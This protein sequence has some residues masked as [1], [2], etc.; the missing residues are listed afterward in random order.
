MSKVHN[1]CIV[2]A[3][4]ISLF[5]IEAL[6]LLPNVNLTA[7]CDSNAQR[8]AAFAKK[9]GIPHIFTSLDDLI[10]SRTCDVAH[11]LVPPDLHRKVAEPLLRAGMHVMV[12]KPLAVSSED[13]EALLNTAKE[14]GVVIGVNHNSTFRPSFLKLK[15]II[16]SKQV[17]NLHHVLCHLNVPLRQLGAKQFSHWMFQLPQNLFLEQGVHPLSQIY[18]L[19][20]NAS[21]VTT[22]TSGR[23]ELAPGVEI[24]DTWQVSLV[25]ERATAQLFLSVGQD[26]PSWQITAICQDGTIHADFLHERCLVQTRTKE[27]DF[28]NSFRTGRKIARDLTRQ[29]I[30]GALGY[31]FSQLKL[32]PKND[33]FIVSINNAVAAFYESIDNQKRGQSVDGQAGADVIKMCEQVT[34]RL[35]PTATDTRAAATPPEAFDVV[36]IGGTGFI[37]SHLLKQLLD[38]NQRV[39]VIARNTR[40]LPEIFHHPNVKVVAGDIANEKVIDEAVAGTP[41]VIHLAHGGGG[42]TWEEIKRSMVDGTRVIAEACLRHKTKRLIYIGTIASLYLGS[43]SEQITGATPND[44]SAETRSLYSR[45]KAVCEDIL[46]KLHKEQN[47]PVVILR[48]GVVIGEG[49]LP[50]HSGV[51]FANQDGHMIGWNQGNNPLPFILVEDCAA[52]IF[53]AMK[54]PG[55]E[56]KSYNLVGDQRPSAQQYMNELAKALGRPLRFYPQSVL[57]LQLIEIG[58]WIIKRATGRRD[59]PFPSYRDLKSR[60]LVAPFDTT[61]AKRDLQWQPVQ[62]MKTFIARG[63]A[64]HKKE[65]HG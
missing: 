42:D 44:P 27:M 12:E 43:S 46:N 4:Y 51:G 19:I 60:G 18:D 9:W 47:L 52:A 23:Q 59:A 11:A 24:Y 25:G 56:G 1:V 14:T 6:K 61:D 65:T 58:K 31:I 63:I 15:E 7:V 37:G 38:A 55:I 64:V 20:G 36:V 53:Q 39:K 10:A 41:V 26:F 5:H 22:L 45:G 32:V 57:K 21:Q 50:F 34:A 40:T 3:G 28:Y 16:A 54:A 35:A 13:C 2:G 17:G 49:G 8:A 29:S 30:S 33:P 62:D 48:P